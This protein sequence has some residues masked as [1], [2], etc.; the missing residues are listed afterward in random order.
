MISEHWKTLVQKIGSTLQPGETVALAESCTG[1]L[2]GAAITSLPGVSVWFRGSIVAYHNDLK[3]S[4]L[5][6]PEDILTREGAV[7]R[8]CALEMARGARSKTGASLGVGLTGI[9]GPGGATPD[10][11]IGLVYLALID[12]ERELCHKLNLQGNRDAIRAAAVTHI[13]KAILE[14]R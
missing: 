11:P 6:V 1:G 2:V 4:L 9:A 8:A 12:S 3:I 7:S 13:L 10:K 14:A 5:D